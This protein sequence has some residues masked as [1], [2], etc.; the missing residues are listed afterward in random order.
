VE[1]GKQV[2]TVMSQ[3][4]NFSSF[5]M[6]DD[7]DD[8][9]DEV[10]TKYGAKTKHSTYVAKR[11]KP[12]KRLVSCLKMCFLMIARFMIESFLIIIDDNDQ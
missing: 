1:T 6:A 8:L 3:C 9:L 4:K 11:S 5:T 10:E 7:I 12:Q 2:G